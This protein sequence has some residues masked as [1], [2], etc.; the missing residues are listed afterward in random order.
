MLP[1]RAPIPH[2]VLPKTPKSSTNHITTARKTSTSRPRRAQHSDAGQDQDVARAEPTSTLPTNLAEHHRLHRRPPRPAGTTSHARTQLQPNLH[3][4]T[5]QGRGRPTSV[6]PKTPRKSAKDTDSRVRAV[7][8]SSWSTKA[9]SAQSSTTH[10]E[11]DM[12]HQPEMQR[13]DTHQPEPS[14]GS[15]A[16][17]L[18]VSR[19]TE[20]RPPT[21]PRCSPRRR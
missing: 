3:A 11:P 9:A 16:C 10:A 6:E 5:H 18:T 15:G 17:C 20:P 2:T 13:V 8:S 21:S 19:D 7:D 14:A 4:C 12:L 1:A